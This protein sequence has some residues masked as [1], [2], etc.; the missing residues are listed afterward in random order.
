MSC[1]LTCF[2]FS[3]VI[4]ELIVY[5]SRLC[6]IV[7]IALPITTPKELKNNANYAFGNFTNC[8]CVLLS[9]ELSLSIIT[10]RV[11]L[12]V[13]DWPNGF[14]FILSFLAPIWTIGPCLLCEHQ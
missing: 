6:L 12:A 11:L 14:A 13:Y 10:D 5:A 8:A 2:I 9:S 4:N 1:E 3:R 7:V